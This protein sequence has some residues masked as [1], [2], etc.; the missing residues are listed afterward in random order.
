M[1]AMT[2]AMPGALE[3]TKVS[4][5]EVWEELTRYSEADLISTLE[6]DGRKLWRRMMMRMTMTNLMISP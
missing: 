4:L 6:E 1:V 2:Q 3:D 5:A